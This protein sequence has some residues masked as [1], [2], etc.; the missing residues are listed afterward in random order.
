[1]QPVGMDGFPSLPAAGRMG[2]V[3]IPGEPG[4][5]A[6]F[7]PYQPFV[8]SPPPPVPHISSIARGPVATV[9]L[10]P[11]LSPRSY[12]DL[13]K[14]VS[15]IGAESSRSTFG[16]PEDRGLSWE[17][18]CMRERVLATSM[19]PLP[20]VV[21][22]KYHSLLLLEESPSYLGSHGY[23]S[24]VYKALSTTD[25]F[26]YC[27]RRVDGF[28]LSN[29]DLVQDAI[30]R[31]ADIK[32]P[33]IVAVRQ[34]F[35]TSEFQ[36]A[37]GGLGEGGSLVY[38]YDYIDLAQTFDAWIA[39][40]QNVSQVEPLV[41]DIVT[42]LSMALRLIHSRGLSTRGCVS[43]SKILV[44][45][46]LRIHIN[47]VG[48]MDALEHPSLTGGRKSVETLQ[49]EDLL[50]LAQIVLWLVLGENNI[51]P[52][53]LLQRAEEAKISPSVLRIIEE[54]V[55]GSAAGLVCLSGAFIAFKAEQLESTQ[56]MLMSE[57]RKR[58]D[59]ARL[60]KI[61]T[62][63]S[64]IADRPHLN[65][66]WRWAST[67]DRY[68]VS[69]FRDYVFF[70]SGNLDVGHVTDCLAKVDIGSFESVMLMNRDGSSVLVTTY[71]DI[72]RCL[73]TSFRE[74]AQ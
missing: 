15:G 46:R 33:N 50:G 48:L 73:E 6:E 24:W 27:L 44:S 4:R 74:I 32:H 29:F 37:E 20:L 19:L 60:N 25:P 63:I 3:H 42:Q 16:L 5:P 66:D 54:C 21:Q 67:G 65:D 18:Q 71:S 53:T 9:P 55:G 40:T 38:V 56:D 26:V 7:Q 51:P 70:Q 49:R 41:W 45:N 52:H 34:A 13:A 10:I 12:Q 28:R 64:A 58:V 35:A 61:I 69:L 31:W 22:H 72:K 57:L 11:A 17:L 30:E 62:K 43:G 14:R 59:V 36:D 2:Y 47:T 68:I 8:P 39:T 1:M 23:R